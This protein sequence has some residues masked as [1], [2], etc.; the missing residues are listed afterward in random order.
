MAWWLEPWSCAL[1]GICCILILV[2][3]LQM[4]VTSNLS[5]KIRD[6]HRVYADGYEKEYEYDRDY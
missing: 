1:A 5:K 4:A 3:L 2:H 6:Y